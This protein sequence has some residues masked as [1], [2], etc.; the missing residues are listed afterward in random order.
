MEMKMML[1]KETSNNERIFFYLSSYVSNLCQLLFWSWS[2]FALINSR[3]IS[4]LYIECQKNVVVSEE[5]EDEEDVVAVVDA[6]VVEDVVVTV[7][8]TLGFL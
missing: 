8:R 2:G 5:E 7:R 1:L 4:I 3:F 6:E